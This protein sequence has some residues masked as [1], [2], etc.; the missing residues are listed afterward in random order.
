MEKTW[1]LKR[2]RRLKR[3]LLGNG[4][5]IIDLTKKLEKLQWLIS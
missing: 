5:Q 1:K 3:V 2:G 4:Y